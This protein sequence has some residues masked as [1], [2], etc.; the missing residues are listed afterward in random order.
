MRGCLTVAVCPGVLRGSVQRFKSHDPIVE[1]YGHDGG[2]WAAWLQLTGMAHK[3]PIMCHRMLSGSRPA[4][5][6]MDKVDRGRPHLYS[7][8]EIYKNEWNWNECSML[9]KCLTCQPPEVQPG[10]NTLSGCHRL[11]HHAVVAQA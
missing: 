1:Y 11:H 2:D 8:E 7:L 5:I 4:F 3:N 6:V 9:Q 10:I